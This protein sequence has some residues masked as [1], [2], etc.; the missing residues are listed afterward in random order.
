MDR[1][2]FHGPSLIEFVL[3]I[4]FAVVVTWT[5]YFILTQLF[6]WPDWNRWESFAIYMIIY[7]ATE[8]EIN[9]D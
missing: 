3:K 1:W 6:G 7:N 5:V 2:T 4:L 9:R 8:V